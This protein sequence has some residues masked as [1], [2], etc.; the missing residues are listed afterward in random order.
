MDMRDLS[1][2]NFNALNTDNFSIKHSIFILEYI[3]ITIRISVNWY[4]NYK[5]NAVNFFIAI[6]SK[7]N[8]QKQLLNLNVQ[9]HHI[10]IAKLYDSSVIDHGLYILNISSDR[11]EE[12]LCSKFFCI[13]SVPQQYQYV[14][15][16]P[17]CSE[18]S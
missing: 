1:I 15:P 18:R 5:Y 14:A 12:I 13:P 11:K 10:D 2:H 4:I 6:T 16:H 7:N 9:C 17:K 8:I 3:S